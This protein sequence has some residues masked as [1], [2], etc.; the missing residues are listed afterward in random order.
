MRALFVF[1]SSKKWCTT[2]IYFTW[3]EFPFLLALSDVEILA[4]SIIFIIAG[5]ETTSSTLYFIMYTLATH[6]DAQK[7]LQEEIDKTLPNKV[8]GQYMEEKKEVSS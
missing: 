6:P 5:Y 2:W 1:F 3:N 8:S 7:K 4:Q